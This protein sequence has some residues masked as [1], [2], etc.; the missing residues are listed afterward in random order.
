[1]FNILDVSTNLNAED[2]KVNNEGKLVIKWS[3]G[4]P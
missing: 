1:M 2:F 4:N 3:E